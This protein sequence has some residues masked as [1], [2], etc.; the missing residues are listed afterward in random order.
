MSGTSISQQ[1]TLY[2]IAGP[3]GSGKSTFT[4]ALSSQSALPVIDPDA[5]ARILR[6]DAPEAAMIE[7]GRLVIER[8]QDLLRQRQS[9]AIETTLSGHTQLRL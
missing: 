2:V 1:P 3:N 8:A 5:V 6:P 9:F 4:L 7:A